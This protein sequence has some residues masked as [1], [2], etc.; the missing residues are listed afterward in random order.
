MLNLYFPN[1]PVI[2]TE[3]LSLR[4]LTG[5]DLVQ[6]F[7]LRSDPKV[8]ELVGRNIRPSLEEARQHIQNITR[9][10]GDHKSFYWAIALKEINLLIGTICF[11]NF[12]IN[13]EI[14][15]IGYELLPEFQKKGFMSESIKHALQFGFEKLNIE[16]ITAFPSKQNVSSIGLLVR[17][18]F[19]PH[20]NYISD[21]PKIIKYTLSKQKYLANHQA[22]NKS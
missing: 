6:I 18:G 20:P 8:N 7:K 15:E 3:R 17:K 1:F 11:W 13:S 2:P 4:Q 10:I 16:T 19:T 14:A 5:V 21:N 22:G 9:L 12:D